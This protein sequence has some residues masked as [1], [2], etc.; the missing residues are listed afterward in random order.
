MQRQLQ[1]PRTVAVSCTQWATHQV[2]TGRNHT[3]CYN[4]ANRLQQRWFLVEWSMCTLSASSAPTMSGKRV[5]W[6]RKIA[7]FEHRITWNLSSLVSQKIYG[8][9]VSFFVKLVEHV[10][11]H[12]WR[13]VHLSILLNCTRCN[14]VKTVYVGYRFLSKWACN[15]C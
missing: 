11:G 9:N 3:R 5:G 10:L 1:C 15:Y 6:L 14:V 13:A 12:V 8:C 4:Q 7:A 2:M